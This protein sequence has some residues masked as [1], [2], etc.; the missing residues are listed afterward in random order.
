LIEKLF[1]F[2]PNLVDKV[3]SETG[4]LFQGGR[5]VFIDNSNEGLAKA[6]F[7]TEKEE[8]LSSIEMG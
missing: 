2:F 3:E 4:A 6:L 8:D 1:E 7:G 5:P